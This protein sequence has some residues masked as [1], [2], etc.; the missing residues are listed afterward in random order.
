MSGIIFAYR[1]ENN[2]DSVLSFTADLAASG[3]PVD[4]M[5]NRRLVEKYKAS[6]TST[7]I[8]IQTDWNTTKTLATIRVLAFLNHNLPSN[9]EFRIEAFDDT[10]TDIID[11]S[12]AITFMPAGNS[13]FPRHTFIILSADAADVAR[14]TITIDRADDSSFDDPV[15]I[16]R[17]WAGPA[18]I[19]NA[20]GANTELAT[21]QQ[22]IRDPS[23]PKASRS[24]SW[25]SDNLR[26]AR[27][28]SISLPALTEVQAVGD[29]TGAINLQDILFEVGSSQ[30]CI[31]IPNQSND[32]VVHKLG[33]YGHLEGQSR[34]AISGKNDGGRRYRGELV[35]VEEN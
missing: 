6:T 34:V 23:T 5:R 13:N 12:E 29:S 35:H 1:D 26:R 30:P 20:T 9:A 18:W 21:F 14:L 7:N 11:E 15:E 33:L 4:N 16:G 32:H 24:N 25:S 10:L 22:A 3:F 31:I 28:N 27:V 17:Y 8:T 2:S 19:P